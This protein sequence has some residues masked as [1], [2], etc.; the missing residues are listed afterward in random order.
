MD[1]KNM[2]DHDLGKSWHTLTEAKP[3][4]GVC[5][6]TKHTPVPLTNQKLDKNQ[7]NKKYQIEN[8]QTALVPEKR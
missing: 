2:S 3:A 1:K 8:T 4:V 7:P 6:T 5:W